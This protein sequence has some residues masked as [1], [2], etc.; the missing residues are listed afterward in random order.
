VLHPKP[1]FFPKA[2]WL[3]K[4]VF[5]SCL[6]YVCFVPAS[7]SLRWE[8][9]KTRSDSEQEAKE[10][11]T[12]LV[13]A[14]G[15]LPHFLVLLTK[16]AFFPKSYLAALNGVLFVFSLCF[17]RT[18]FGVASVPLRWEANKTRSDSEQEAKEHRTTLVWAKVFSPF[19]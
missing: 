4:M 11:R 14:R 7:V 2:I 8:A 18:C 15:F 13:W 12:T 5:C 9:N 3:P 19:F 10:H 17:L 1:A 16:S 6:L